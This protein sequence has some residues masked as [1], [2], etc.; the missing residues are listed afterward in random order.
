MSFY[1]KVHA[2]KTGA[3]RALLCSN[4]NCG[5]GQF[6]DDPVVLRGAADYVEQHRR[7]RRPQPLRIGRDQVTVRPV[8]GRRTGL[9]RPAPH[10][11]P[12][13]IRLQAYLD[14]LCAA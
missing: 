12:I 6:E 2:H 13:C 14:A 5:L 9:R 1:C 4:C 10:W 3:V 11:S 8:A 7:R